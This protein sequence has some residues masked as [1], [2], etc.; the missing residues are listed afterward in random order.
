M[1]EQTF[2]LTA[3][4]KIFDFCPYIYLVYSSIIPVAG[5]RT[6]CSKSIVNKMVFSM[7]SNPFPAHR[8]L[9]V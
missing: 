2:D 5:A 4:S 1:Y 6:V 8:K 7:L 9:L 3:S